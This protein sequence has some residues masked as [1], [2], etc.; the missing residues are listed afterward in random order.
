MLSLLLTAP[1]STL[2]IIALPIGILLCLIFSAVFSSSEIAFGSVNKVRLKR[3]SENGS[4]R[5]TRAL[6]IA[7]NYSRSL[8]TI[9][10]VN[11]LSNI[12]SSSLFTIIAL[13]IWG[14]DN[15]P[16]YATIIMTLLIL[17][18]GEILPKTLASQHSYRLSMN[19]STFFAFFMT[20]F[21]PLVWIVD[22]MVSKLSVIWTPKNV[23]HTTDEEL[24]TM[25]ESIEED[26]V[27]DEKQGELIKSAIE[28]CEVQAYE[29]TIPRV[30]VIAFDIE[31]DISELWE[32]D[33]IY[34]YSRIP[35]YEESIDNII[36]ILN[37]KLLLR[38]VAK[39]EKVTEDKLR[40]ML[41]QPIYVHK[42]KYISDILTDFKREKSYM[43]VV[44]DEFGG[45][46][47]ILTMEDIVEQIIGDIWDETDVIEE[48][49]TEGKDGS[50]VVDGDT[51]INEFFEKVGINDDDFD[52]EYTTVGGWCT[53]V[54]EKFP[55]AGDR[56]DYK[57]I[58][59][60][61]TK[62]NTHRVLEVKVEIHNLVEEEK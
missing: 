59:V 17:T 23:E 27:L 7:D 57:N 2:E 16:T 49:I 52:S 3:E 19:Y 62:V 15:G 31:E 55:L 29:I 34:T 54:L 32:D 35:V 13:S 50:L 8:S 46:M 1:L 42:T 14:E 58:T 18:F 4:K 40:G 30:D 12:A 45:T 24:I 39:G 41:T 28:F 33:N 10:I 60:L 22:K 6:K 5:A 48:E 11:N 43:A 47:G 38:S 61:V 20:V 51:N 56:F 25:V 44:K 26:G 53:E 9:L 37:T 36:G 21:Q